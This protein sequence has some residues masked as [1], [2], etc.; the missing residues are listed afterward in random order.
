M[1]C[2][3]PATC[4]PPLPH[5]SRWSRPRAAVPRRCRMTTFLC[6]VPPSWAPQRRPGRCAWPAG[7]GWGT[8]A[9][10]GLLLQSSCCPGAALAAHRSA[11]AAAAADLTRVDL[12]SGCCGYPRATEPCVVA[13]PFF[14]PTWLQPCPPARMQ[15]GIFQLRSTLSCASPSC[16]CPCHFIHAGRRAASSSCASPSAR[17]T[18][19][20]RPACASPARSSTP[21]CVR[22][23]A[24]CGV[25]CLVLG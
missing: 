2:L 22:L 10:V 3:T 14:S 23:L 16:I 20:S 5:V 7:A 12:A 8:A 25:G 6:G 9:V 4:F 17:P 21:T 1:R 11:L 18:P 19:T 24:C 13:P 15:G